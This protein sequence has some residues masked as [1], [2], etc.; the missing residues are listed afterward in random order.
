M[1]HR[2]C[3]WRHHVYGRLQHLLSRSG[4]AMFGVH[5][6]L[7]GG[8]AGVGVEKEA[9]LFSEAGSQ[10]LWEKHTFHSTPSQYRS[11]KTEP[12]CFFLYHSLLYYHFMGIMTI[13]ADSVA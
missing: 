3:G 4:V 6:F 8:V 9:F 11:R 12:V 13:L 1:I 10:G 2:V 7:L 5:A